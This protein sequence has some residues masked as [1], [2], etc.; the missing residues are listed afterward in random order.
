MVAPSPGNDGASGPVSD[1]SQVSSSKRSFLEFFR[2]MF[3]SLQN[4]EGVIHSM[5][6]GKRASEVLRLLINHVFSKGAIGMAAISLG[7]Q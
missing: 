7:Y 4:T 1:V 5:P 2:A 6:R 3:F